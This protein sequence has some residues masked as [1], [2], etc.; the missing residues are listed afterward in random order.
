[1]GCR[2]EGACV[3]LSRGQWPLCVEMGNE[4]MIVTKMMQE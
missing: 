3:V 4:W 1:M 2:D